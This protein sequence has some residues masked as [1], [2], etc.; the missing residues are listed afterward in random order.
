MLSGK[1]KVGLTRAFAKDYLGLY[2]KE[3]LV[4]DKQEVKVLP[5]IK[6]SLGLEGV[7]GEGV[8]GTIGTQSQMFARQ[9][10]QGEITEELAPYKEGDSPKLLHWK[11]LARKDQLLVRQ[12]E[13][14]ENGGQ[15]ILLILSPVGS[16]I[17]EEEAQHK[18]QDRSLT[19]SLSLSHQFIKRG[20]RVI[21]MYYHKGNWIKAELKEDKALQYLREKLAGY[22]SLHSISDKAYKRDRKSVV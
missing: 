1:Q 9:G 4:P 10:A 17:V 14:G 2:K 7:W 13:S 20:Y 11:I 15:N 3:I 16:K 22:E 21:F 18:L 6:E 8:G 19:V 12:R 5:E